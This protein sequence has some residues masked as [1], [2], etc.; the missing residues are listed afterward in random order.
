M[1]IITGTIRN[2]VKL[3]DLDSK[4]E[5]KKKDTKAL[6]K[7]LDPE[8]RQLIQYQEDIRQI[9]EGNQLS[10]IKTKLISGGELTLEEI[11]YLKKKNPQLYK[12]YQDAKAEKEAYKRQLKNCKTKEDVDR[13]KLTKMQGYMAQ[14]K[15]ITNN[16]NIPKGQKLG[17][18]QRILMKTSFIQKGHMEFIN[19]GQYSSLPTEAEEAQ[20]AKKDAEN[21]QS[22]TSINPSEETP[23]DSNPTN[24]DFS[25]QDSILNPED[26]FTS[27]SENQPQSEYP[28]TT[29]ETDNKN[30]SSDHKPTKNDFP[31]S[32]ASLDFELVKTSLTDLINMVRR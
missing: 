15:S 16:P 23:T 5:Q 8:A 11:D 20:E 24:T 19:S 12:E 7:N 17:M 9:R 30:N 27:S 2:A 22:I 18:L 21:T 3:A 13:V 32:E 14:A 28:V 31:D 10:S 29:Q 26:S 25:E 6:A 4:W 1:L